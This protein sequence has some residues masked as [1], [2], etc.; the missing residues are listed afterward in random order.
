MTWSRRFQIRETARGSL[1]VVPLAGAVLGTSLG[2]LISYL[3]KHLDLPAYWD[4]SPATANAVLTAIIGATAALAGFVVTVTVLFVQMAAG[5]FSARYMRIWYRDGLLKSTLAALVGTLTFSLALLR[6]VEDEFVPDAGVT[7]AGFLVSLSVLLFLFFF[8]RFIQRLRPVAV[9]AHVAKAGRTAFAQTVRLA[10]R[11]DIRWEVR[12]TDV[13]PTRV[14]RSPR[15][16]AIQ[17]IDPDGLVH[18][19]REHRCELLVTHAVGDFVSTG[20]AV[21]QIH[22]GSGESETA[23]E[24]LLGMIALGDERTINQD[25]AFAIRIMVDVAIRALSPAVNDPTTAVQV[26]NYLGELLRLIGTTDLEKRAEPTEAGTAPAVVML[27]RRWEDFLALGVT[28][29]RE[30][31][32]TSIQVVRR[33]RAM[34]EEL[35]DTVRPEH[36]AAV[37]TELARLDAS[38]EES[39]RGSV[40]RDLALL[41]DGQGIGG[42]G[43]TPR[44]S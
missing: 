44:S 28:E 19:A 5:S 4:Y 24:E 25:P 41:A 7:I 6:R 27:A 13:E 33:L 37:E 42:P 21:I 14:V 9:A 18:W 16:G 43:A 22:G 38:V 3:D 34:L 26:L 2:A 10:D 39:W 20:A 15:A 40:D 36:R 17:A 8:S 31:G 23:D 32:A 35:R 29:I 30:Y 11:P 1:W 12:P